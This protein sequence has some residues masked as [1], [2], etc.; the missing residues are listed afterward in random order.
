MK[1]NEIIHHR[2]S[3][4]DLIIDKNEIFRYLGYPLSKINELTE[5]S[6][7]MQMIQ[8]SILMMKKNIQPQGVYQ[9]F[10]ITSTEN[11]K[12]ENIIK[13]ADASIQSND[14]T[15]NLSNCE[16]VIIFAI[17]IGSGADL[18]IKKYSKINPALAAI[19]QATGSMFVESYAEKINELIKIEAKENGYKT[20]P[21]FSPG[22]GDLS[23]ST[24]NI[25]FR[26]LN[27]TQKIGLTLM[28]SFIMAPEKS[29]TAFIGL[30]KEEEN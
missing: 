2:I 23:L 19:L 13:F 12:S 30:E 24:Q 4:E 14:L 27:C 18:L 9:K 28:D 16:S 21:R 8:E 5:T 17:T 25:F 7:E 26:L 20:H 1:N 10:K 3:C 15:K 29:I 6:S 11:E 22:Y